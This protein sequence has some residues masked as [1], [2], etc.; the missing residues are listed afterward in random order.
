MVRQALQVWIFWLWVG[1]SGLVGF[2]VVVVVFCYI[3]FSF[4]LPAT[5]ISEFPPE[6]PGEEMIV[7][8]L[9]QR[10]GCFQEC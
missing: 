9:Y 6:R 3:L 10:A 7:S 5:F 1:F 8:Y 4:K 2:L